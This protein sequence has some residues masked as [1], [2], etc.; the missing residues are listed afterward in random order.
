MVTISAD[1]IAKVEQLASAAE[2]RDWF[3]VISWG[4]GAADN[5]RRSDGSVAWTRKP[6]AGWVVGVGAWTAGKVPPD[7]G[8]PLYGKVRVLIQPGFA[9]APFPGG[10]IYVEAGELKVRTH[11]I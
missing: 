8:L 4:K 10:E 7:A 6:D 9:P 5:Y 1:A 2:P 3:V 11:A